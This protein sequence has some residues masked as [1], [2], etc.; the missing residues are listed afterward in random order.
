[1]TTHPSTWPN[2]SSFTIWTSPPPS[3]EKK[4]V[5]RFHKI[6]TNPPPSSLLTKINLQFKQV[7]WCS[8]SSWSPLNTLS[9]TCSPPVSLGQVI[10]ERSLTCYIL[11]IILYYYMIYDTSYT[12]IHDIYHILYTVIFFRFDVSNFFLKQLFGTKLGGTS[13]NHFFGSKLEGESFNHLFGVKLSGA[14]F[15]HFFGVKLSGA[16]FNQFNFSM[17]C[18]V[19]FRTHS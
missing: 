10:Y 7:S 15:N 16:S 11:Y 2:V 5:W 1:M 14:S 4:V 6:W 12:M 18:W 8:C 19:V 13:F 17:S 9:K 3:F